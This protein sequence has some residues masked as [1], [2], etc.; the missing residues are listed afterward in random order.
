MHVVVYFLKHETGALAGYSADG[1]VYFP[2][3]IPTVSNDKLKK[4]E[5]LSYKD[6][7][8]GKMFS[9]FFGTTVE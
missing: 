1:G 3:S 5:N 6:L 7:V 9:K 2:E 4:W 8:K